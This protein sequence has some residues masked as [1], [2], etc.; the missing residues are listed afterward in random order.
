MALLLDPHD[1]HR[2]DTTPT[3]EGLFALAQA[4]PCWHVRFDGK[5]AAVGGVWH[6]WAGRAVV[7]GFLGKN[8]GP[9][10]LAM[11]KRVRAE[12]DKLDVAR[13][14]AYIENSHEAGHT[15]IRLL[16]FEPES[17]MRRFANGR[18]YTMYVRLA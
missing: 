1:G 12:I 10:M 16:G 6:V 18:D 4:G 8:S 13:L 5:I 14:E 15:W 3:P 9:A 11:T 17:V 7:W 2:Y